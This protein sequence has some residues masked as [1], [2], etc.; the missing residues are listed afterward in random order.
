MTLVGVQI[1]KTLELYRYH[2][3]FP[4]AGWEKE[5]EFPITNL[6][7]DKGKYHRQRKDFPKHLHLENDKHTSDDT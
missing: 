4:L 2:F 3:P 7:H 1:F 6:V 5:T